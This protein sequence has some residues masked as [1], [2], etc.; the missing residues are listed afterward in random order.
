MSA[1]AAQQQSLKTVF[2]L[3]PARGLIVERVGQLRETSLRAN[4]SSGRST[5]QQNCPTRESDTERGRPR[6]RVSL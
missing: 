5:A 4:F 3:H 6:F 1:G 2:T